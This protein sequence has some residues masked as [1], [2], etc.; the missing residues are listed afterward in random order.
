MTIQEWAERLS[1]REIGREL[2]D[3]EAEQLAAEGYVIAY[4]ESDDLL[5]FSG[6]IDQ[7]I[8]AWDG[9]RVSLCQRRD[10]SYDII[11]ERNGYADNEFSRNKIAGM[12]K[13]NAIWCPRDLKDDVW[14][15]WHIEP[16]DI[17]HLHFDIMEG[18]KLYCR[19]AIFKSKDIG[20]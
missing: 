17:P 19:A 15:S 18:G 10:G 6:V 3:G 11:P 16:C 4:G 13:I 5:E 2:E 20:E 9:V 14:A 1:G 12:E 7:E 8:G